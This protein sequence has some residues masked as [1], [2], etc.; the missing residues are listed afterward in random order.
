MSLIQERRD[1]YQTLHEVIGS[2]FGDAHGASF[3][4]K[5]YTVVRAYR[6]AVKEEGGD[7]TID[8]MRGWGDVEF[9]ATD[10]GVPTIYFGLGTMAAAHTADEY[11]DL[12]RYH[13][14]VGVYERAVQEFLVTAKAS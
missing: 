8:M 10:Y 2:G 12:D 1:R 4:P 11:I 14:S 5:T 6:H 9:V 3:L 7:D 13:M